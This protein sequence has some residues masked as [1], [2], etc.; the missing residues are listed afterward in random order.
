MVVLRTCVGLLERE[1]AAGGRGGADLGTAN[2]PL[3]ES[4][5]RRRVELTAFAQYKLC[6]LFAHHASCLLTERRR[7]R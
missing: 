5:I 1:R 7:K 2:G 4:G 3:A 6:S